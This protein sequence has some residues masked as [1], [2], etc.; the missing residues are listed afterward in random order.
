M[1]IEKNVQKMIFSAFKFTIVTSAGNSFAAK[2]GSVLVRV[3]FPD[4][5]VLT[6]ANTRV[7][8]W[9]ENIQASCKCEKPSYPS[10]MEIA[11]NVQKMIFFAF[12]FTIV[13]SAGNS[14]AAKTG[15]VLVRVRFPGFCVLT[16]ANIRVK[17]WIENTRAPCKS[18][19]RSSD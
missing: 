11:K 16:L 5:C 9:R 1:E 17:Q 8:Q 7:K 3:R 10:F 19:N 13:T 15:S 12:K 18:L 6:L 2:T 4:F 14:C